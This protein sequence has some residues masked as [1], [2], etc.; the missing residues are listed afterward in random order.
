MEQ[1]HNETTPGNGTFCLEMSVPEPTILLV[2]FFL[3]LPP[4]SSY[5]LPILSE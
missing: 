2:Q 5:H 3:S 4:T 1:E